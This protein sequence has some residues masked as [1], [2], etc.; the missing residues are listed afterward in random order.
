MQNTFHSINWNDLN[1]VPCEI[2]QGTAANDKLVQLD[3]DVT[4]ELQLAFRL[5][6][7]AYAL[8]KKKN[9][10]R[11]MG[12]WGDICEHAD[13]IL[14]PL[15][16]SL[17]RKNGQSCLVNSEKNLQLIFM[18]PNDEAFGNELNVITSKC[19]KGY[20]TELKVLANKSH[21]ADTALFRTFIVYY[22]PSNLIDMEN[23]SFLP[24]EIA[25]ATGIYKVSSEGEK[26]KC[27]PINHTLRLII[28][29]SPN[30]PE[31]YEVPIPDD[32]NPITEDDFGDLQ[33][34]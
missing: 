21:Y 1:Q 13:T 31:A 11:A 4:K 30:A 27:Y 29:E 20:S 34:I 8:R 18:S 26:T 32:N 24:F 6:N 14:E 23:T 12:R 33:A 16:W 7:N 25:Y 22:Q 28:S 15:G 19:H 2:L 17:I 3:I 10:G 9:P 5:A